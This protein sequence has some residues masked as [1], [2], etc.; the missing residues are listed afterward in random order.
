MLL[1]RPP[2]INPHMRHVFT[3]HILRW[4]NFALSCGE[5]GGGKAKEKQN[6]KGSEQSQNK[7]SWKYFPCLR[8]A[9]SHFPR[10]KAENMTNSGGH[11]VI[12]VAAISASTFC[13][14]SN[15]YNSRP[16]RKPTTRW[17][18]AQWKGQRK[19]TRQEKYKHPVARFLRKKRV[20]KGGV[21]NQEKLAKKLRC[22]LPPLKWSNSPQSQHAST[23]TQELGTHTHTETGHMCTCTAR[24]ASTQVQWVLKQNWVFQNI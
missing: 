17:N 4:I 1:P 7:S 13:C 6:V 15:N 3:L 8:D 12:T 22:D 21:E 19:N 10:R 5:K 14:F 18:V 24:N 20:G 16:K 2:P 11:F 9:F 23:P